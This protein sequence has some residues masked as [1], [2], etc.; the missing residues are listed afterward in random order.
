MA[1][2]VLQTARAVRLHMILA[3]K[4]NVRQKETAVCCNSRA[5]SVVYNL[6]PV[7]MLRYSH[8]SSSRDGGVDACV[9][10]VLAVK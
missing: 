9:G 6:G 8:P 2:A 7:T 3:E 10:S 4:T 5:A 1:G